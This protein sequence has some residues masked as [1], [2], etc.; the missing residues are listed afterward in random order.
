M[1]PNARGKN[2]NSGI[3]ADGHV[4]TVSQNEKDADQPRIAAML[5]NI[6]ARIQNEK[7]ANVVTLRKELKA[8]LKTFFSEKSINIKRIKNKVDTLKYSNCFFILQ[9]FECF[10]QKILKKLLL[11]F[12]SFSI[13]FPRNL[14]FLS[15]FFR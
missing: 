13:L 8:I 9:I 11:T 3:A 4:S 12:S 14:G 6:H 1:N 10:P 7:H 2:T 15:K 5:Q